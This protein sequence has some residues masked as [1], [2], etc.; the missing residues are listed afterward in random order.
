[1]DGF[2]RFTRKSHCIQRFSLSFPMSLIHIIFIVMLS[3]IFGRRCPKFN[4]VCPS[5][6]FLK[7][8]CRY[9]NSHLDV[10]LIW[11]TDEP[12]LNAQRQIQI[13]F[14]YQ[15]CHHKLLK[16]FVACLDG[17]DT[18]S[19]MITFH[20]PVYSVFI[21][22]VMFVSMTICPVLQIRQYFDSTN[23][24]VICVHIFIK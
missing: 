4:H 10:C 14:E 20:L 24:A 16:R 1:M 13:R 3:S 17:I 2:I 23:I 11:S 18:S 22:R 15:V 5:I 8:S 6:C 7:S 12:K 9:T 21:F 19:I